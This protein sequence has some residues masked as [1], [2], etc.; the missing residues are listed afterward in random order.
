MELWDIYDKNGC[1]TDIIKKRGDKLLYGE[2][3]LAAEIWIVNSS[4][5]ILI[6]KRSSNREVLPNIWGLTT[7][8][9]ISG[10]NSL[11]GSI[12]EVNEEIGVPLIEDDLKLIRR[13]IRT[14]MIW[15][16]YFVRKD[17]DLSKVILQPEEV[18]DIKWV[19]TKKFKEMILN[20]E[21]FEYP[22]IYEIL[23]IL[24]N[25]FL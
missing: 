11:I 23:S 12:R 13:I 10:E 4:S 18:S 5:E 22:E 17:Y 1:K 21:I 15:D 7:G 6:Q 14:D 16:I 24:E 19:S 3:H 9:M 8:C 25:T 2:Y 20:G